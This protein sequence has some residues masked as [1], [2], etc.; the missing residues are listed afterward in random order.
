[1]L[2]RC[3]SPGKESCNIQA[4][5]ITKLNSTKIVLQVTQDVEVRLEG[6]TDR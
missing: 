2:V 4:M 3:V 5:R 1:M 6:V